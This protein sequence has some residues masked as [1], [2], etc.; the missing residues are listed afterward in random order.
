MTDIALL[1]FY[2]MILVISP[3]FRRSNQLNRGMPNLLAVVKN[4]VLLPTILLA[5]LSTPFVG[6]YSS[7]EPMPQGVRALAYVYGYGAG[8]DSRLNADGRLELLSRPLNRSVSLADMAKREP[9]LLRLQNFLG[10]LDPVFADNLLAA[11]LYA[12]VSVFESRKVTGFLWGITDR[13]AVGFVLPWVRREM[14]FR[15]RAEV[16]NNAAAIAASVGENEELQRG[17]NELANYPLNSDTFTK[18]IFLDRG[19]NAPADQVYQGWGDLEIENRYTYLVTDRWG[20][21]LRGSLILPTA[22]HEIDLH[23]PLDKELAEGTWAVKLTHLSE[24]QILPK[25]VYWSFSVGGKYRFEKS[26]T[27]AY[28]LNPDQVLPDLND[29]NQIE[30]VSKKIGAEFNVDSGLQLTFFKG[31]LSL[32][33]G[34]FYSAKASDSIMGTRGL[35]YGRETIGTDSSLQGIELSAEISTFSAFLRNSF[36]APVKMSLAYVHPTAGRNTIYAPYWRFDSVLLF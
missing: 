30:N 9:D 19:Y 26:Q 25:Q 20:L 3:S 32:S 11:N 2:P 36:F 33:G 17:L 15:F 21:G 28:A 35:D 23:D 5:I 27:R 24:Y 12:D 4:V 13:Y 18:S 29:P 14:G 1:V 7:P 10:G 8:I 6:A 16:T 22:N 31:L 34:Y